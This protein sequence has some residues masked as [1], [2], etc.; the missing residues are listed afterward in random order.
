ML[1]IAYHFHVLPRHRDTFRHAWQAARDALPHTVGLRA[2]D[3][4][5]P[6]DRRDAFT[7]RLAWDDHASFER[8]TRTWIGVWMVNGMG[9]A[10]DAFARPIETHIGR[11]G[12]VLRAGKRPA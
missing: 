9:L 2:H 5:E 1:A 10:R 12:P 4:V 8:F 11:T 6:R 7:L 3:F